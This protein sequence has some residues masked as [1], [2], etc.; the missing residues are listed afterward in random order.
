[1]GAQA[2]QSLRDIIENEIL[3]GRHKPG[4]RLDEARLAERFSVSR[5]PVRQALHGLESAGLI[6]IRPR[7]GAFVKRMSAAELLEMFETMAEQEASCARFA[8]LRIQRPQAAVLSEALARCETASSGDEDA[9]YYE[10][11]RFHTAI[12]EAAGNRFLKRETLKLHQR[13]KPFRRTQLRLRG[14]LARSQAEHRR[15]HDA[16]LDGAEAEAA[17]EAR[18]HILV[19]GE[20]LTVMLSALEDVGAVDEVDA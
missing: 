8:A 19:Q 9:Y 4:D 5:T 3:S 15:I 7:R 17:A 10:N 12:Y 14:R 16:I 6:E 13:L 2:G 18:A 11:E 1:M 20:R